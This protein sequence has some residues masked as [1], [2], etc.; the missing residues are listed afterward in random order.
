MLRALPGPLLFET[1]WPQL[2]EDCENV[3]GFLRPTAPR[4]AAAQANIAR[5]W[6]WVEPVPGPRVH[7]NYSVNALGLGHS[8]IRAIANSAHWTGPIEPLSLPPA[9]PRLIDEPYVVVVPYARR[10][11]FPYEA[12]GPLPHYLALAAARVPMATVGLGAVSATETHSP[13][14][15][16]TYDW[17]HGERSIEDLV[18]L[19]THAAGAVVPSCWAFVF[20]Y[21][22]RVPTFAVLGGTIWNHPSRLT[23]PSSPSD[24][25]TFAVPDPY[26]RCAHTRHACRSKHIPDFEARLETWLNALR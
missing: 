10:A 26:C 25:V 12:R 6:P 22:A 21:A 1:V 9:G 20:A 18:S 2:Y 5:G 15:R 14:L 24:H 4:G 17:T 19:F 16:Y 3:A 7:L 13:T 23:D 8:I 11:G